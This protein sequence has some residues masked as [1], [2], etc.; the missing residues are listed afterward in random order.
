MTKRAVL[1]ARVSSDDRAKTGGANLQAQLDLCREYATKQGYAI[2]A[3]LAEDDRGA[4]GATFDL[5]QLSKALDMAR[6]CEFDVLIARELDRLARDIAKQYIVEQE[7]KQSTVTI[8]YALYD[9]APTPEGQL[10]KSIYAA[11]AEFERAKIRERM[12]RGRRRKAHNGEVM[13][14]G[15]PPYGYRLCVTEGKQQL[16]IYELEAQIIRQIFD[17]YVNEPL[18]ERRIAKRLTELAVPTWGDVHNP[19]MR[20]KGQ[21]GQWY[22][23]NIDKILR[24]TTYMG[25]F[26]YGKRNDRTNTNNPVE[27]YITADVPAIV[28]VELWEAAQKRLRENK[29]F[30][31]RNTKNKYLL[32]YLLTC[33]RCGHKISCTGKT[34][35]RGTQYR[36]YKC[37][38]ADYYTAAGKCGSPQFNADYV[39]NAVWDWLEDKFQDEA[40][41]LKALQEAQ[42][43]QEVLLQP[44]RGELETVKTLITKNQQARD[45]VKQ[46]FYNAHITEEEYLRDAKPYDTALDGL[47]REQTRLERVIETQELSEAKIRTVLKLREAVSAGIEKAGDNFEKRREVIEILNITGALSVIDGE[48]VL[49]VQ[50]VVGD[51]RLP[52]VNTTTRSSP[53]GSPRRGSR[54]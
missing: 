35:P 19:K 24:S 6:N 54:R 38:S 47:Y 20:K 13:T 43:E 9:F 36:Y 17:W 3:E 12:V 37:S 8:E 45:R 10:Q 40:A 31:K 4:S 46:L 33:G 27:N 30:A 1:Y 11:F 21:P 22:A 41:L 49:D 32:Q 44:R 25:K 2:V 48:K 34:N 53:P 5:P 18:A 52:V 39:D 16:E 50:C 7:L 29:S 42:V 51:A 23:S 26:V 28:S 14:H 15:K